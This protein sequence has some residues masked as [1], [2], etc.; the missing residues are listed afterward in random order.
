ME[1][2]LIF[3]SE[4]YFEKEKRQL[5]VNLT[6]GKCLKV[7]LNIGLSFLEGLFVYW[8]FRESRRW[9]VE[10]K[11][12]RRYLLNRKGIFFFFKAHTLP[13]EVHKKNVSPTLD[14]KNPLN[15]TSH[16]YKCGCWKGLR[17]PAGLNDRRRYW[18]RIHNKMKSMNVNKYSPYNS[19]ELGRWRFC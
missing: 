9:T 10:N 7:P 1:M 17:N 2:R 12:N 19:T 15:L 6:C 13:V 18:K 16:W 5:N 4:S 8:E 14:T 11:Y 3:F